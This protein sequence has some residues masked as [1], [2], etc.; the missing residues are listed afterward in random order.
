MCYNYPVYNTLFK[1]TAHTEIARVYGGIF[2]RYIS[3]LEE[4]D[5][6]ENL[7]QICKKYKKTFIAK[8]GRN[9]VFFL[10]FVHHFM[11]FDSNV[12]L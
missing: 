9:L 6:K 8:M 12:H 3:Y 10:T 7:F 2:F 1:L 5:N 4:K 11:I